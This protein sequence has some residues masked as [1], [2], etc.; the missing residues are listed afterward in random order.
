MNYWTTLHPLQRIVLALTAIAGAA[1]A[2]AF[3]I[4]PAAA[5]FVL[6]AMLT[7]EAQAGLL[8][9]EGVAAIDPAKIETAL[10]SI[11]DQVKDMAVKSNG[12]MEKF[13][14]LLDGTKAAA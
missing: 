10:K 3:A 9:A 1:V 11:N 7:P 5:Q 14:K 2:A 6:S 4:D 8:L 12:E 13:G